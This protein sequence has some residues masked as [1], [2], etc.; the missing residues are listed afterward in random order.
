MGQSR[1]SSRESE[2]DRA[3]RG[4][5]VL[6]E[7]VTSTQ[8][9]ETRCLGTRPPFPGLRVEFRAVQSGWLFLLPVAFPPPLV[10]AFPVPPSRECRGLQPSVCALAPALQVLHGRVA[11]REQALL[12]DGEGARERGRV[13]G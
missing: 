4:A 2:D 8:A 9:Q 6:L 3:S 11:Q 12:G 5:V 10:V 13:L 1:V 7:G